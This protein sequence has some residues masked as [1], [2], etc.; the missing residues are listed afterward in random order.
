MKENY[1]DDF[2]ICFNNFLVRKYSDHA[3]INITPLYDFGLGYKLSTACEFQ[4]KEK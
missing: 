3:C 2:K 4:E 1:A